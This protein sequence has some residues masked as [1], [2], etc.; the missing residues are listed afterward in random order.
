MRLV[1]ILIYKGQ[2]RLLTA[3]AMV[4]V[5][6]SLSAFSLLPM[7]GALA[8][9][10]TGNDAGDT[11]ATAPAQSLTESK[12]CVAIGFPILPGMQTCTDT[13]GNPGI[14]NNAATGGAI[15]VYL[16]YVLQFL[17]SAV[18]AVVL[19]MLIIAGV[20]YITSGANPGQVKAAKD[21]MTNAII[22][23]VLFL[24]MFAILQYLIPGG[25]L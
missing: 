1:E 15:I 23:L 25:V 2:R 7:G 10:T 21:R 19:L 3:I 6:A 13:D 18:A 11:P 24:M 17:S 8:A 14:P 12:T 9:Q 22:A 4:M 16:R 20:Q 5:A